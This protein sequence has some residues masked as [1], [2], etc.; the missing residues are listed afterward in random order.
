MN[1][2]KGPSVTSPQDSRGILPSLRRYVSWVV[3]ILVVIAAAVLVDL[4]RTHHKSYV[5]VIEKT[6]Y[7]KAQV[8]PA[9]NF[10]I[11]TIKKSSDD[12]YKEVFELYKYR[13]AA[14]KIG[15]TPSNNDLEKQRRG[16]DQTYTDS[17]K[18]PNYKAWAELAAFKSTI[19]ESFLQRNLGTATTYKGYSFIFWFGNHLDYTPDYT[20]PGGY[21]NPTLINQDKD[22]AKQQAQSYHDKLKSGKLTADQLVT[23][24]QKDPKLGFQYTADANFSTHFGTDLGK[25]W[26]QQVVYQSV[27]DYI[28]HHASASLSDIQTG[29]ISAQTAATAPISSVDAFYYFVKLDGSAPTSQQFN[30]TLKNLKT[31]YH[32]VKG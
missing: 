19:Q 22:Y 31:T 16:L 12:A 21:S 32:G 11:T 23:A 25:A 28:N 6:G 1:E 24:I 9:A 7:T 27:V 30:D 14:Q 15:V 17:V 8:Q 2:E 20:P 3:I 5:F 13:A 26:Q 29:K 10:L 4:Y 18:D